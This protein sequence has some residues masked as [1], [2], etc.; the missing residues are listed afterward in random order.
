MPAGEALASVGLRPMTL[1]PKE[2]LALLNGT[3]MMAGIGALLLADADRLARTA[4]VVAALS[5][6][7]LLG[8]E[9][10][11]SAAYQ[12][13]RPHP[14]Q[15]RT[16]AELRWLL[17]GSSLQT[18]ASRGRAPGPGLLFPALRAPGARRLP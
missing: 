4:S 15:V 14:G 6:E 16:A 3:Q 17:R 7:A 10:A 9:V 2:G 1:E 18:H 11:F 8:T 12:L 5:V 13:A